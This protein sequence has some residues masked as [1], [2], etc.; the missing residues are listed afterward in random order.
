MMH[1]TYGV[2]N[3][4][5]CNRVHTKNLFILWKRIHVIIMKIYIF[6]STFLDDSND[7]DND[8]IKSKLSRVMAS[9]TTTMNLT[10]VF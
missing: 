8:N 6:D 4:D 3:E 1:I 5:D 7:D 9:M 10:S 2:R